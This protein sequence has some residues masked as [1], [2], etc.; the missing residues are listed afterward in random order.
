MSITCFFVIMVDLLSYLLSNKFLFTYLF[1]VQCDRWESNIFRT[2][3]RVMGLSAFNGIPIQSRCHS[4]HYSIVCLLMTALFEVV[5]LSLQRSGS[6]IKN[7]TFVGT[8][9]FPVATRS[10]GR[11]NISEPG[12]F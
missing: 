5:S 7:S 9:P 2:G 10:S 1:F 12:T 8:G 3:R 6:F 4:V 11:L